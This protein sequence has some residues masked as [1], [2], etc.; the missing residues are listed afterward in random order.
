MIRWTWVV[1]GIFLTVSTY[2]ARPTTAP[3]TRPV[4]LHLPGIA[5]ESVMDHVFVEGLIKGGVKDD[6][7]IYDWVS[8]RD[9][10]A[11]TRNQKKNRETSQIVAGWVE[12]W[13]KEDPKRKITLTAHSAG[14]GI[15]VWALEDLPEGVVVD[16][17][18]LIQSAL[19]PDYDLS[20]ALKHVKKMYVFSSR[21]DTIVLGLMT[22]AFWTMDG[23]KGSAA[24]MVGFNMPP[25][26]DKNEYE[27]LVNIPYRDEWAVM[28]ENFGSHICSMKEP[29]ARQFI[30]PIML[31]GV[32][33][34]PTNVSAAK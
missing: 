18:F 11:T 22:Q 12:Q 26:A 34:P 28:F 6:C 24:G 15:A 20:K 23:V 14:T 32:V 10:I 31:R 3:S 9:A 27:K 21:L 25:G 17:V 33:P 30:A 16:Q 7:R 8:F 29:F 19:S 4:L 13:R 1:C 2:A 5:G